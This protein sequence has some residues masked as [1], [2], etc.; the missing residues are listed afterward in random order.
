MAPLQFRSEKLDVRVTR[1]SMRRWPCIWGLGMRANP[2]PHCGATVWSN[3]THIATLPGLGGMDWMA[4]DIR[5]P[6]GRPTSPES[7]MRTSLL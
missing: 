7:N 1:V 4:S 3:S 5:S 6:L 2:S